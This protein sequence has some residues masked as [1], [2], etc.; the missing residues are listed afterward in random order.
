V[1]QAS[2]FDANRQFAQL[3]RDSQRVHAQVEQAAMEAG[4]SFGLDSVRELRLSLSLSHFQRQSLILGADLAHKLAPFLR[5]L[6]LKV[7]QP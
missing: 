7:R 3:Q 5:G 2:D 6:P 4:R 1:Q